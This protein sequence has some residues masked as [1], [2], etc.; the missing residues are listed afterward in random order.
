MF[1]HVILVLTCVLFSAF[2]LFY[3]TQNADFRVIRCVRQ[4]FMLLKLDRMS[5]NLK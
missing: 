1:L 5:D 2:T 4:A 3:Y